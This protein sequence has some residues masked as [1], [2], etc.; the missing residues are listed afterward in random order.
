MIDNYCGGPDIYLFITILIHYQL[1]SDEIIQFVSYL[2]F[3]EWQEARTAKIYQSEIND[4][5]IL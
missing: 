5:K 1:R 3:L 4:V 2:S